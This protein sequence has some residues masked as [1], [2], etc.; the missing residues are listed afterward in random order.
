MTIAQQT[1]GFVGMGK[2]GLPICAHLIKGGYRVLGYRRSPSAD[3]E[4]LGGIRARSPAAIGAEADVVLMCLPSDEALE[5]VVHGASGLIQVA[6]PGQ[7]VVEL[8][9]HDIPV[10]Q[11][12]VAALA[13]RGAI[14]LDGEVSGTPGM[15]MERKAVIYL[16]GD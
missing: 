7:I 15:V 11:R 10:K 9:S 5:E 3:F 12:Y 1:I 13:G 14:F 6:C 4:E 16:A 8:G 2:I